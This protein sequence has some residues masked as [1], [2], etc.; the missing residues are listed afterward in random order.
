MASKFCFCGPKTPISLFLCSFPLFH[1]EVHSDQQKG[2]AVLACSTS[3]PFLS[4]TSQYPAALFSSALAS[5]SQEPIENPLPEIIADP[6]NIWHI[7]APSIYS[8]PSSKRESIMASTFSS[9]SSSAI[10]FSFSTRSSA[11]GASCS[12]S[13][14]RSSIVGI[15]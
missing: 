9:S 6:T 11:G 3:P 1:S 8:P 13:L 7:H 15:L 4:S 10:K 14:K 12:I 2:N 5:G